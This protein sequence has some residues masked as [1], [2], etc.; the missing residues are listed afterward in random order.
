MMRAMELREV[1]EYD[2]PPDRVFAML[3]DAGW[4]ERVCEEQR[5]ESW[6]VAVDAVDDQA[7]VTV[8]RV[9]PARVPDLVKSMVGKTIETVQTEK[10]GPAAADGSRRADFHVQVKGQPATVTGEVRL[11]PSGAGTRQTVVGDVRVKIP[12]VGKRIEPEIAK[13]LRAGITVER[14]LGAAY[15]AR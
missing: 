6:D 14:R 4:R 9:L 12:F 10:W 7:W 1:L 15:L 13:A 8:V 3:G 11:E 5:A 2:A